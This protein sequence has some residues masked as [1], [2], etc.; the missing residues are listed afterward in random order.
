M[1]T[2]LYAPLKNAPTATP[3]TNSSAITRIALIILKPHYRQHVP[4]GFT[5]S[6]QYIRILF[7]RPPELVVLDISTWHM[8]P[9]F[10]TELASLTRNLIIF[11]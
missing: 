2:S 7:R 6:L 3:F 10:H 9:V 5:V 1:L 8:P 4:N 11:G